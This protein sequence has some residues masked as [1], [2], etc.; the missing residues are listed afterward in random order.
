[1]EIF[2]VTFYENQWAVSG[3]AH[4]T[5]VLI[6]VEK[7][8]AVREVYGVVSRTVQMKVWSVSMPGKLY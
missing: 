7:S 8:S 4:V 6:A 2:L 3:N 5:S 1:M